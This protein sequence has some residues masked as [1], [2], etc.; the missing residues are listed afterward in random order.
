MKRIGILTS[1]GD[2]PGMNAAIRAAVRMASS[3]GATVAG[4]ID[5]FT[6]FVEANF[7]ELD[8]RAV[9]NIIQRG[10][11][12]IGTSRCKA[13]LDAGVRRDAVGQMRDDR[14][15]GLIVVGGD[16]SFRGALALQDELDVPVSG[17]PGTIDNDVWGTDETIGFDTAVNTALLAIDQIR[18]TSVSTGMMFFVEVMG[19]TS[20]AIALHTAVAGGAAG[21]LVPEA[22]DQIG[23]LVNQLQASIAR[24]KRSHI[25]VVAEGDEAGGAFSVGEA[26]GKALDHPYRVAVL[27]HIQRGG[28]PTM[29]DRLVAS[30]AGAMA[31]AALLEGR[32]GVMIGRQGGRSVEVP[33]AEVVSHQHP[34]P[35]LALL[36]LAQQLSG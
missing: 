2:G 9:G 24:G 32:T 15:E 16:G 3:R 5:G 17:V 11:T 18:D 28:R 12:I 10:G 25:V 34:E 35:D 6:G 27:G 14:I 20:G 7:V 1:G 21:V 13:F 36:A 8:D 33:L 26:V 23:Q 4:Y 22:A 30:E 29:R 19:R 31:A